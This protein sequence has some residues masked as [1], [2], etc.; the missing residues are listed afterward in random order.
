MNNNE[1]I[2]DVALAI[3]P[4]LKM[5][6]AHLSEILERLFSEFEITPK[7]VTR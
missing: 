4:K 2:L 7:E 3:D 6:K 1:L 5:S